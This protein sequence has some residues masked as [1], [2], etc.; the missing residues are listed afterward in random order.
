MRR[1]FYQL[2]NIVLSCHLNALNCDS[3]CKSAVKLFHTRGP[4]TEKRLSP[5][6][7]C[8]RGSLRNMSYHWQNEDFVD[9]VAGSVDQC[10]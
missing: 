2:N 5:N 4:A 10:R 9:H 1:G 3:S 8:V 6:V 7:L